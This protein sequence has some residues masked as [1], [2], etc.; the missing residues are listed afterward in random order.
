MQIYMPT[1]VY[2]EDNCVM[3]HRKELAALGKKALLVTGKHSSRANGSLED[4]KNALQ[5]TGTAYAVFDK[6]EENPSIETVMQA[7]EFGIEENVDFVIGIGG[8]S[9]MDAAKAIALMVA[10][11]GEDESILYEAH[12]FEALP[13]AEV[14]TTAGTG[15]EVTPYAI[16]TIHAR[17]TKQSISY[18]IYPVLALI[19]SRYL[20]TE[21]VDTLINTTVDALAH[22][23]ESYLNTNAN[24]YNRMYSEKGLRLFA[25]V[26]DDLLQCRR[27]GGEPKQT[28]SDE[29]FDM[30]MQMSATA[31][32][33]ITHTS[34][35]LPHG[36]S[37]AVTYEMGVPHGKA[38]GIFLPGFLAYYEEKEDVRAALRQMCFASVDDFT[39]YLDE[40]LGKVEIADDLWKKDVEMIMENQAKLKNY[41]FTMDEGT[42]YKFRR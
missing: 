37:Y 14:P 10:N 17:R 12:E 8:G 15:S 27:F 18:R 42:L 11:P 39:G 36:L 24:S 13:V 9:P 2:S 25:K 4:V 35:S 23:I 20:K 5:K 3:N 28:L 40:L 16:L 1:N 7:R 31:G 19:D 41:P 22:L 34:T 38:V 33:A 30:L 32:M 6:I 29:A 21:S 26:K